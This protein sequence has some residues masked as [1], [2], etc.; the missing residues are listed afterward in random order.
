MIGGLSIR[1]PSLVTNTVL[2]LL[3]NVNETKVE[4]FLMYPDN[5]QES[6]IDES[7]IVLNIYPCG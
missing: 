2:Q 6:V 3:P 7:Y 4:V 1:P 5:T